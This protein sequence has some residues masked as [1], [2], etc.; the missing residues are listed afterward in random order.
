MHDDMFIVKMFLL[1]SLFVENVKHG[2][3][4]YPTISISNNKN[5]AII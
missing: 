1:Y 3:R 4:K 5:A 2:N